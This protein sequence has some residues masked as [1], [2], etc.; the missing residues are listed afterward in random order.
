MIAWKARLFLSLGLAALVVACAELE[1]FV[2][3][4]EQAEAPAM[5]PMAS[6]SPG[7][8]E[9]GA[10]AAEP[11]AAAEPSRREP[12]IE[13]GTGEVVNEAFAKRVTAIT[14]DGD[15]TLNFVDAD[16][17]EVVRSVIGDLLGLNYFIDPKVEGMVTVQTSRPLSRDSLLPALESI[18]RANGAALVKEGA[19]YKVVPWEEAARRAPP[20]TA[21]ARRAAREAGFGIQI[22]PLEFISAAEMEK[23]LESFAPEGSILKADAARNLLILAGTHEERSALLEAVDLFD[24]DWLKGMSFALLPLEFAGAEE[25]VRDLEV[26]FGADGESPLAGLVRFVPVARLNAVLVISAQPDYLEQA[27][28]WVDR[29]DESVDGTV[30]RVYVYYVQNGRAAD[31]AAV[32]T[33]IFGGAPAPPEEARLAPGLEPVEL[34]APG[35]RAKGAAMAGG[36]PTRARRAQ[37]QPEKAPPAEAAPPPAVPGRAAE[38]GIALAP[39]TEIRIIADEVNNALVIMAAPREYRMVEEA[40]RKLDILPLQVLIE[41]TILEVTLRDELEYGLQWFFRSG[42]SEVRL[43]SAAG[44]FPS[45]SGLAGFS[46]FLSASAG[47]IQVFLNALQEITDVNVISSP[48]LM[49]L[50]NQTARIQVGDQVPF[51]TRSAVTV[52]DPEAPIVNEVELIDTGVILNVTPRVNAGGLVIMEIEQQVSDP[53]PTESSGIDAPTIQQRQIASSVAIQSGETVTLG[54]LIRDFRTRTSSGI[55]GLSKIPILGALFG[56]R[57]RDTRR[58]ELLVLITPRVVSTLEEAR[59]VTDE[60]RRRLRALAPLRPELQ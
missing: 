23:I 12:V 20:L 44:E 30:Q 19:L 60:L 53:I 13:R 24:V 36:V 18:L 9:T 15:V 22:V 25:L 27:Q 39:E 3:P 38:E 10:A 26:V 50:D 6:V 14:S 8:S 47:D 41:A 33:E 57:S 48:S 42:E 4:R 35:A 34:Y 31:L 29:L 2:Q 55:P 43:T 7:P 1:G 49:V 51:P 52:I 21:G 58:T 46:Y 54:G 16:L 56:T 17:R 45:I 32:L 11:Q 37:P 5:G 40:I 28:Q 59:E